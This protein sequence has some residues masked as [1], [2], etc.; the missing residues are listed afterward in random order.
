MSTRLEIITITR[1]NLKNIPRRI[2]SSLVVVI[3]IAGVIGVMVAVLAMAVGFSETINNTGRADRAIV[4]RGG[5]S[6][7]VTSS[8]S[9]TAVN[10]IADAPGIRKDQ[11]GRPI[12]SNEAVMLVN[13]TQKSTG[14]KASATLRGISLSGLK[15]RPEIRLTMGRMFR[16]GTRE[17]LVGAAAQFQFKGLKIG[18]RVEFRGG[19]WTVVGQFSSERNAH[20]SELLADAETVLNAYRRGGFQSVSVMLDSAD[21]FEEFE[22]AL[23]TNPTLEVQVIRE[24]QYYAGL[25]EHLTGLMTVVGYLVGSIMALGAMF[26]ALNTMYS[27]VSVRGVEIATLRAIGYGS[28]GIVI[29]V[30][31]EALLLALVGGIAGAALAWL[32][33]NGNVVN[34]LGSTFSQVVFRLSVTPQLM[35]IG[36]IWALAI[37]FLGGLFPA[38]RA[39]RIPVARALRAL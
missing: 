3:G 14:T 26:G 24:T 12:F 17:L 34:T 6:S 33:F 18:D 32:L 37:G 28:A 39:A 8:L 35:L 25:S 10:T 19:D 2:G 27:A 5:A 4:L 29:S 20:E 9:R 7:E 22:S 1:M 23:T 15:L 36:L 21:S 38:R 11:Q 30:L 31:V 13:L 16:S